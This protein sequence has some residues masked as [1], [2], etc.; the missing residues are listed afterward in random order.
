NDSSSEPALV[1]M[2]NNAP[3]ITVLIATY[4]RAGVLSETLEA[5]TRVEQTGIDCS[6]VVIDNNST[7]NTAEVV[8]EYGTRLPLTYLRETRPGKSRALNK[9]L[10][11]CALKE[12]V[13]F[14]DDDVTPTPNWFQE[15]VSSVDKWPGVA[16]FGGKVEP[17]WPDNEQPEWALPDWIQ[18][19]GFSRH[20]YA[21]GEA[22]YKP[23]ACPFGPNFWV[24]RTVLQKVSFFDETMMWGPTPRNRIM[25]DETAFL[26]ELQRRG[27]EALYYA[28][29]AVY[30]RILPEAC[31]LPWLRHRAYT[32]G[33][34]QVRLLGWHRRNLYL[35][36]KVLWGMVLA[37]D[38][39]YAALR[40]FAGLFLRDSTRN[41]NTTVNAMV[42]FGQLHETVNQIVKHFSANQ[43]KVKA[44]SSK[45]TLG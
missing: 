30:H 6:I 5:L 1:R 25:G 45:R 34:G 2:A 26:M 38:E 31:T 17:V 37:A 29:A 19:F 16:V 23:P 44:E 35:K 9:A 24:R 10:G 33:R 43:R 20:H 14:T 18:A 39:L 36:S 41:C 4:N 13:V 22:F 11:E 8:K 12:I 28:K 7:D 32:H 21:E 40:L 27:Y 42:R 15:I 3:G